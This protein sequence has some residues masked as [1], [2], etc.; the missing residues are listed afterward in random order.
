MSAGQGLV[1]DN[2][3]TGKGAPDDAGHLGNG[4]DRAGAGKITRP[5]TEPAGQSNRRALG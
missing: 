4:G 2:G 1:Q 5:P 3:V